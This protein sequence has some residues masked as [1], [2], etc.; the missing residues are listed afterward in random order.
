[1][2]NYLLPFLLFLIGI[3]FWLSN[4]PVTDTAGSGES[5][6][7]M[8]KD[9]KGVTKK[10]A[11]TKD[12]AD[13][14][15]AKKKAATGDSVDTIASDDIF[16]PKYLSNWETGEGLLALT[17]APETQTIRGIYYHP[18]RTNEVRGKIV[19]RYIN[20]RSTHIL[21]GFW[22]QPVSDKRC[23]FEKN[24]THYWG[25]LAFAFK[26]NSFEGIWGYCG[27]KANYSW[28]GRLS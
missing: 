8:A 4:R 26:D 18:V 5:S 27:G 25:R 23:D 1:M 24:G 2:K 17:Q 9:E 16:P 13:R 19:S 6:T 15:I 21:T 10:R 3:G 22:F 12:S 14:A 20:K 7:D 28:N 11:D